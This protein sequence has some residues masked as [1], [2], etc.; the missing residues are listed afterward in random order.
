MDIFVQFLG[1]PEIIRDGQRLE[2]QQKKLQA[3]LLYL[4]FNGNCT[5]DELSALFWC[6]QDEESARRNLRNS[7]YKLK[8]LLGG[9]LF[10][11][12]GNMYV[13]LSP[14]LTLRKDTDVFITENS[15]KQLFGMTSYTFL[16]KFYIKN[17]V[18][19][20]KWVLSIRNIYEKMAVDRLLVALEKSC[21]RGGVDVE[22]CA[23]KV[24]ALDPYSERACRL[25]LSA[26]I[27]AGNF[28]DALAFYTRF[29]DT[30]HR[31]LGIQ[32]EPETQELYQKLVE[33]RRM[34]HTWDTE[35]ELFRGHMGA[36]VTIA[37]EYRAF[38]AGRAFC[39]CV[40]SG[41]L[42]M[43][44]TETAREFLR[45]ERVADAA[46]VELAP[47][48]RAV[49]YYAVE[50]LVQT[51]LRQYML[52]L[53]RAVLEEKRAGSDV[54]YVSAMEFLMGAIAKSGRKRVLLLQNLEFA[55]EE[56]RSLLLTCLFERSVQGVFLL[57]E[58]CPDFS[59]GDRMLTRLGM[60][61]GLRM[62]TLCP[63]TEG[64]CHEY[65]GEALAGT[66]W[67]VPPAQEL[68]R[69]TG[70]R[71]MLLGDYVHNAR[72]GEKNG[73]RVHGTT[74]GKLTELISALDERER[75]YLEYLAVLE[76][77]AEIGALCAILEEKPVAVLDVVDRLVKRGLA[78]EN[79]R[80]GHVVVGIGAK[81]TRDMV[82]EELSGFKSAELHQLAAAYYEKRCTE[83]ADDYFYLQ[84]VCYHSHFTRDAYKA[85]HYDI[86]NL[87]YVLDYYDEFF[88]TIKND[89]QPPQAFFLSREEIYAAFHRAQE[90]MLAIGA[91][92]E[93]WQLQ[94][95]EMRLNFLR[96]RTLNR[97]GKRS[98]GIV[99][100]RELIAAA[101][102]AGRHDM[103]LKGYVETLC[104][105]VKTEDYRLMS[106]FIVK[107][108]RIC[109]MQ[110]PQRE[111]GVLYRLDAYC[112]ILNR[113]YARAERLLHQSISTFQGARLRRS[114]YFNVAGAYNYL[115]LTYRYRGQYDKALECVGKAITICQEH[116]VQKNL[117]IFYEDCGYTY[118]MMGNYEQAEQY[119]RRSMEIYD[120]F[121]T[122]WLRSIAES[123]MA[124]I[125][126]HRGD[127]EKALEYFRRAEIFS[128]KE[129]THEELVVLQT[130]RE[131]LRA[132]KI[133]T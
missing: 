41:R 112:R 128:R 72:K 43:H 63:L 22:S 114:N 3:L 88:P 4:L 26:Y 81:M 34:K 116:G 6:N 98:E 104:Y 59:P 49:S 16:E 33:L 56:S 29:A 51:L 53:P 131:Q 55:D 107:A 119:F 50:K 46:T 113:E 25:L 117:D 58:C 90:D 101:E 2:I 100:I 28:S 122:Y 103:L 92:L 35:N 97:D 109:D 11:T 24:L 91:Q 84:E 83:D 89:Y 93:P 61:P 126:T 65:V 95:F 86:R 60:L 102:K 70:G 87:E 18:E 10:V 96:G 110:T 20:E 76:N 38:L 1:R 36:V 52:T 85:L 62:L 106:E 105:G 129:R 47:P 14:E 77:G 40:I 73:Y 31:E 125:C 79:E 13:K 39:G 66:R 21:E 132:A 7:L 71:L 78:E 44:K 123:C 120:K 111:A 94:D 32:P 127:N 75:A 8:L 118:F 124:V 45:Q 42:G 108:Y 99:Y 67:E 69:Q 80:F 74:R 37:E 19:Y 133:I 5:R 23:R 27:G 9:E 54:F 48:D 15:E 115:A 130:A 17:C 57:A 68:F 12:K 82:Y 121:D 64:E 30:L